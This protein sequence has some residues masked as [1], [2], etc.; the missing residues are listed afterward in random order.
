MMR[1]RQMVEWILHVKRLGLRLE[2]LGQ[3]RGDKRAGL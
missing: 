1:N 3:M 2:L